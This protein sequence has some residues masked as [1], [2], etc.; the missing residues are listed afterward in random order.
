[1]KN[2]KSK[3][4]NENYFKNENETILHV[5]NEINH[6]KQ[7][8]NPKKTNLVLKLDDAMEYLQND[9][10]RFILV[11]FDKAVNNIVIICNRG[12]NFRRSKV[13][14]KRNEDLCKIKRRQIKNC[15]RKCKI[16]KE[17]KIQN[18]Y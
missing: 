7:K 8:V 14:S 18:Q 16:F 6:I 3:N 5:E 1:M 9:H 12:G 15:Q 17:I 11:S 2:N 10:V 13:C 4:K